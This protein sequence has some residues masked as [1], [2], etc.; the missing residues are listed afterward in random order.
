MIPQP[1]GFFGQ[2][3]ARVGDYY[4]G[5]IVA[6]IDYGIRRGIIISQTDLDVLQKPW[7]NETYESVTTTNTYGSG[8]QNTTN[9]LASGVGTPAAELCDA[10]S[11]DGYSDWFLPN[12]TELLLVLG[13]YLKGGIPAANMKVSQYWTSYSV[14]FSTARFVDFNPSSPYVGNVGDGFRCCGLAAPG[15]GLWVRACRFVDFV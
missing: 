9:I 7:Q 6:Y 3:K 2:Q 13:N 5:G 14:G 11:N 12:E 8:P 4:Q 1:F 15:P 10:Y